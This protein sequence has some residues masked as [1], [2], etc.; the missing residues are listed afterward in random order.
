MR[1]LSPPRIPSSDWSATRTSLRSRLVILRDIRFCLLEGSGDSEESLSN[2]LP[3]GRPFLCF[4]DDT[5]VEL[6]ESDWYAIASRCCIRLANN[7]AK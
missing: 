3:S 6:P 7:C 2:R 1:T 5:G 4:G